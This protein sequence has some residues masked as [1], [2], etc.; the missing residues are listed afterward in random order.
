MDV[1]KEA[2]QFAKNFKEELTF[3]DLRKHLEQKINYKL[4]FLDTELAQAELV[5]LN[6][7]IPRN[8]K[9]I[10]ISSATGKIIFMKSNLGEDDKIQCLLHEIGHIILG[11]LNIPSRELNREKAER[12]AE[13]FSYIVLAN[14]KRRSATPNKKLLVIMTLVTTAAI[15]IAAL[16]SIVLYRNKHLK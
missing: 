8:E 6:V 3:T 10:A 2:L 9:S 5:R 1:E 15:V 11:H 13:L 4:L 16:A 12:D 14:V 7:K